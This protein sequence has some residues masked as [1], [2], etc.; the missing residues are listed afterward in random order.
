MATCEYIGSEQRQYP[1]KVCG[2]QTLAGK[3]Y[4]GDHYWLVYKKGSASAGRRAEK[5]VEKE[6]AEL[7]R[8]QEIEEMENDN[9]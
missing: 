3:S 9:V 6:I 4:C 7:K 5:E 8:Q 1:F 2:C